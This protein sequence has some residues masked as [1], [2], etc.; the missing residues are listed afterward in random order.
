MKLAVLLVTHDRIADAK[1]SMDIV[2]RKWAKL[3]SLK[4]TDI[5]HAFNGK[6]ENYPGKYL[7]D[8]ACTQTQL[9]SLLR[10]SGFI[11]RWILDDFPVGKKYDYIF[12][13]SGDV[14]L[15]KPKK[16]EVILY[17][18]NQENRMLA[19]TLW[20]NT[21]FI[22][23]LFA[24]EFFIIVPK[25][26]EKVFPVKT[27]KCASNKKLDLLFQK[28]INFIPGMTVLLTELCFTEK[29]LTVLNERFWLFNWLDEVMFIP[30][31]KIYFG[32]NRY[33]SSGL[34]YLSHHD[35]EKKKK[36]FQLAK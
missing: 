6:W 2:R 15:T 31:R 12:A 11:K 13:L 21:F 36:L 30:G 22:P 9:R 7:E 17:K 1:V 33:Y 5:Y 14:W 18:M 20:P 26:A 25:L 32:S 10:C 23:D 16:I 8:F 19:I 4:N 24:T 35:F 28:L 3:P 29:V 27:K 34:R